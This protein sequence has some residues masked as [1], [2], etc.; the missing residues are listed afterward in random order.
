RERKNAALSRA[1]L[2]RGLLEAG[3][4][5]SGIEDVR[6]SVVIQQLSQTLANLQGELAQ[7]SSTLLPNHPTIKA[8]QAQVA[9]IQ[10]QIALEGRRV[11]AALEAEARIEA[12][13]EQSL[14][15]ELARG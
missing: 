3:Q 10:E 4:P 1:N 6:A 9:E 11:A 2:I 12:D 15:D 7:R 13:L 5:I 14:E 8:L